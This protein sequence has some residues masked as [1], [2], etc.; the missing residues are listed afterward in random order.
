MVIWLG[1]AAFAP[2]ALVEP[3]TVYDGVISAYSCDP[4]P[5]NAMWP[6]GLFRD[7]TRPQDALHGRVAAGPLEWLGQT[8]YIEGYGEVLLV[9]TPRHGWYGAR[10]HIDLFM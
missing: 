3:V 10:P 6:C 7:G 4:H 8:V 5:A 1:W 9:D 2:P